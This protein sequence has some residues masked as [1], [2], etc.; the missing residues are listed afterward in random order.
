MPVSYARGQAKPPH[1]LHCP[2][3]SRKHANKNLRAPLSARIASRVGLFD[4]FCCGGELCLV[5]LLKQRQRSRRES[6]RRQPPALT[7]AGALP[8][9]QCVP[10]PALPPHSTGHRIADELVQAV[11]SART[12][13]IP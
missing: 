11:L 7:L 10:A 2:A 6:L 12:E 4:G 1:P 5:F 9:G 8:R 13:V 3:R